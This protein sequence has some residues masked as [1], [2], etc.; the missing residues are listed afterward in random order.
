MPHKKIDRATEKLLAYADKEGKYDETG[1]KTIPI[2]QEMKMEEAVVWY[3]KTCRKN[4]RKKSITVNER[5]KC[6][7]QEKINNN[8]NLTI[9]KKDAYNDVLYKYLDKID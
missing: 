5:V 8:Q 9:H 3:N 7:S 6:C 4:E 1:G 2:R